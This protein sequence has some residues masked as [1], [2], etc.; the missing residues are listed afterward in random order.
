MAMEGNKDDPKSYYSYLGRNIS[1]D[2]KAI[3]NNMLAA[4]N[5]IEGYRDLYDAS[6]LAFENTTDEAEK[7]KLEERMKK[8]Y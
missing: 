3:F 4:M 6:K 7:E 8:F 1:D 5:K 2:D